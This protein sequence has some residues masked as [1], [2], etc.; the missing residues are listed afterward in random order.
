MQPCRKEYISVLKTGISCSVQV[1]PR[2]APLSCLHPPW[3]T[4]SSHAQGAGQNP[5]PTSLYVHD[6]VPLSSNHPHKI[7]D[8]CPGC[9]KGLCFTCVTFGSWYLCSNCSFWKTF[10]TFL[11]RRLLVNG[12]SSFG[13]N[14]ATRQTQRAVSV[15]TCLCPQ[16]DISA[17]ITVQHSFL[18]SLSGFPFSVYVEKY[19]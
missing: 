10:Q 17:E 6:G 7:R 4:E 8:T 3:V 18:R 12:P 5:C 9:P 1:L 16:A 15:H 13:R 14:E 2:A 19:L 11:P